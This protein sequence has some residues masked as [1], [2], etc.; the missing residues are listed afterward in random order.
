ML[1]DSATG[2]LYDVLYKDNLLG[3]NDWLPLTN[4]WAGDGG[5]MEF[6]DPLDATQRFYRVNVRL[7]WGRQQ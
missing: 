2:R 7:P 3:T 5:M 4:D 6:L 1:F